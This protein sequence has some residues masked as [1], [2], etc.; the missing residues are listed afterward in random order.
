MCLVVVIKSVGTQHTN[1]RRILD[2]LFR[3]IRQINA[4]RIA[5]V[6]HVKTEFLLLDIRGKIIHVLHHQVPVALLR[7]TTGILERLDKKSLLGISNIRSKLTH[8]I[9]YTTRCIFIG[10]S[11]YLIGLNTRLQRNITQGSI[12]G[13]LRRAQKTGTLQFLKISTSN[14]TGSLQSSSSLVDIPGSHILGSHCLILGIG[15]VRRH[16][17][18]CRPHRITDFRSFA[19]IG[20]CHDISGIGSSSRLIGYPN[21][22]TVNRNACNEI[23]Q[24]LHPFVIMIPEISGKEEVTILLIIGNIDFK[25]SQ[26]YAAPAGN[27]LGCTLLLR[28]HHLQFQ[29]S[30]LHIG[31][32][33]EK[34]AGSLD[35]RRIAGERHITSLH[36][37]DNLVFL[38]II[39]QF[40]V[41]GIIIQRSIRVIIQVHIHL[42]THLTIHV[43]INLLIEVH[44][45]GFSVA[46]RQRWIIDA[47]LVHTQFQLGRTLCPDTDTTRSENLLSRSQVEMHIR[48]IE[49]LLTLGLINF[50]ILLTEE[51]TSFIHLSPG[52]IFFRSKH[53]RS[54]EPGIAHTISDNETVERIVIDHI[55]LHVV[56]ALQVERTLIE[57]AE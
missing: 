28:S 2:S 34:A 39:L 12:D 35:K 9:S 21:L 48:E 50:I 52:V 33:T 54:R 16:L 31:S 4:R 44:H 3:D 18:G 38:T 40:H 19:K 36:K 47:L 49:L 42:I 56:R 43:E 24:L 23:R 53:D 22:H 46:D 45:R 32:D 7:V 14:Q 57:V 11:Q 6:F 1:D 27:T 8:L 29:L 26:L 51:S 55:I 15:T 5:L 20:Q 17:S 37:L 30:K 13:I 41:L 25:W 10:H